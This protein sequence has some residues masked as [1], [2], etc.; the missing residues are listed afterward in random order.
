[1]STSLVVIREALHPSSSDLMDIK[2]I[3]TNSHHASMTS[4]YEFASMMLLAQIS[5]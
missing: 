4:Y 2:L 3:S 5:G 1:M